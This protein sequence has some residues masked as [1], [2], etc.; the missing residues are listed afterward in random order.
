MNVATESTKQEVLD[1]LIV[2][3]RHNKWRRGSTLYDMT[4]PITLGEAIDLVII[5]VRKIYS[6]NDFQTNKE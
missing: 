1:A 4:D 6:T 3:E 5:E 2:L